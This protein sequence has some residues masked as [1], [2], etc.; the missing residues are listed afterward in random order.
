MKYT[1]RLRIAVWLF[2]STFLLAQNSTSTGNKPAPPAADS[3]ETRLAPARPP[4]TQGPVDILTDTKGFDIRPYLQGVITIVRQRW[5]SVMPE[6][7][8]EP[9]EKK[10][11]VIMGF[12]IKKDGTIAEL[13]NF[14][15]SGDTAFDQA[16]YIGISSSAPFPPLPKEFACDYVALR[17]HFYY[18]PTKGDMKDSPGSYQIFPCVTTSVHVIGEVGIKVS[19]GSAELTAGTKEQFSAILVGTESSAVTWSVKGPGCEGSA[20]GSISADGLYTAPSSV[21]TPPRIIVTAALTSDSSE[22]DSAIVTV[23][24]AKPH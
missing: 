13:R 5:Y 10:G 24:Q 6:S 9:L 7:A 18:N 14:E 20:C 8:R 15:S 4:N 16:A 3:N 11:K 1:S 2:C 22:I 17:F 12:R 21:P 19:P 23:V